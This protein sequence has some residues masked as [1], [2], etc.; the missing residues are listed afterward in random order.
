MIFAF[1]LSFVAA[2]HVDGWETAPTRHLEIGT[3]VGGGLAFLNSPAARV[4]A[5]V[6]LVDEWRV[7]VDVQGGV[8]LPVLVM[9]ASAYGGYEWEL[10]DGAA[11][12][13]AAAGLTGGAF[14][15]AFPD[16][17]GLSTVPLVGVTTRA[18]ASLNFGDI[19]PFGEMRFDGVTATSQI[20]PLG[21]MYAVFG[22]R[23]AL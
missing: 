22:V 4:G 18:G 1:M 8:A 16:A 9:M 21:A 14:W 13:Y 2:P 17:T 3:D 20:V 19:S 10:Y 12:I 11:E 15:A 6:Q 23:V 5:G 7:G